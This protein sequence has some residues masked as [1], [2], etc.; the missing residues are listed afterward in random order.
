MK[1]SILEFSIKKG[2]NIIESTPF[3]I[4]PLSESPF[5]EEITISSIK[6]HRPPQY[7]IYNVL[8]MKEK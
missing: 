3:F 1:N 8:V 6:S 7:S 5:T 2:D 4:F